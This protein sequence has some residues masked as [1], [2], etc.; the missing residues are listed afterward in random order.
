MS[1]DG[2]TAYRHAIA[3]ARELRPGVEPITAAKRVIYTPTGKP[4]CPTCHTRP[5][6]PRSVGEDLY[7]CFD[8]LM[9]GEDEPMLIQVTTDGGLSSPGSAVNARKRKVAA[10]AN[11]NPAISLD[12][13]LVI[14]SWVNGR[15]MRHFTFCGE[16]V[17]GGWIE[18]QPLL[19]P[20][21]KRR[22]KAS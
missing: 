12:A 15:H 4:A 5:T 3:I 11:L 8:I 2:K 16:N 7:G 6:F 17:E 1:R 21:L 13:R 9:L 14:W 22:K 19:S 10:W 20:L 18:T